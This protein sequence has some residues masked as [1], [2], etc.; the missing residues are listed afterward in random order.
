MTGKVARSASSAGAERG[1]AEDVLEGRH[2]DERGG[3]EE[4]EGDAPEQQPVGEEADRAERRPLR[5][6]GDGRADLA[7]DDARERHRRRPEVV[8]V[9][10][11]AGADVVARAPAGPQRGRE[12]AGEDER[13]LDQAEED[14]RAVEQRALG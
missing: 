4:L 10:R 9:E 2:V 14:P 7:R 8:V 3:E 11:R 6:G 12:E 5:A 13:G 1:R